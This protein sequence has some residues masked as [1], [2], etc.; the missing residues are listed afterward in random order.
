MPYVKVGEENSGDIEIYYEDHGTGTPVVL[1]HGYPLSGSAWERQVPMLIDSGHRVITY[2]R[3]GWGKSSQPAVG[4]NYDT[5]TA[6]FNTLIEKLDL[7]DAVLVGHSMGTGEVTRY[8]GKYGCDRVSKAVLISPIPP[9]LVVADDDP[10]GIP[11][12]MFDGF[13]A[14]AKGDRLAWLKGF[15]DNFYNMDAYAGTLVSDQA[16][17]A[18]FNIAAAGSAIA[19]VECISTWETD[20]RADVASFDV[21]ILVI[22][23]DQDRILPIELTGNRLRELVKNLTLTVIEG[24]PH[25]IVWTHSDQVNAALADFLK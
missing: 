5:Y 16:F 13:I 22:Q 10:A 11:M 21:P 7:H 2:D 18:S 1:A 6:D 9:Y 15:L 3:R 23:G 24:G 20:F 25:G 17:Q 19:A 4:H 14:A 8:L 12:S